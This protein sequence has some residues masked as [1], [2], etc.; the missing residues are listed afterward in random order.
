MKYYLRH[1]FDPDFDY[2][3]RK[4][5]SNNLSASGL[6]CLGYVQNAISGQLLAEIIP[7]EEAG[8]SPDPRFILDEMRFPAGANT[9]VLKQLPNYLLSAAKGFVFYDKGLICVK[10]LLNVRQDIS[11]RTGNIFFVGDLAIHGSLRGGF[12]V[13][14]DNI[15]ILGR[16]EGGIARARRDITIDGGAK[17]SMGQHCLID[18]GG[19]LCADFLE[20]IEARSKGSM[21]ID[22]YSLYSTVYAGTNMIVRGQLYG[23]VL[24]AGGSVFVGKQLGNK[25]AV[26]TQINLGYDP[27]IMRHLEK[28]DSMM[29]DLNIRISHLQATVGHLPP[30]ANEST[31]KLQEFLRQHECLATM[32]EIYM[33]RLAD[34]VKPLEKCRLMV[35]GIVYPGVEIAIGEAYLQTHETHE[36]VIFSLQEDGEIGFSPMP[37]GFAGKFL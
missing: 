13:Q 25:A 2:T 14:A 1:F 24:H 18:A 3:K 36:N 8:D 29:G 32:R 10:Q 27:L 16:I 21:L 4:P 35:A 26:S 9:C 20:K 12:E 33:K 11:F 15:H 30:N 17:G 7:L 34:Q 5:A 37:A 6:Y 23:G 31:V 19:K 28:L 22:K